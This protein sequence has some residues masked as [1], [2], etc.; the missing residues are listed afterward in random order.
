ML[1]VKS[2]RLLC[3]MFF[4]LHAVFLSVAAVESNASNGNEK[5]CMRS[6]GVEYRGELQSSSSGLT[7]LNWTNTTRDYDVTLHPDSQTGV[8]DHNYCRNPDSS[9]RPWCYI[10]GPDGTVQKQFCALD[11]CKEQVPPVAAE[12]EPLEPSG[13]IPTTKSSE[14]A[15]SEASQGKVAPV[16]P[17]IGISRRVRTGPTKKKDLGTLGYVIG[18]L[19]MAIIILLGVGITVGYF[20]K[21]GR[22]L[23]KHHEQRVYEREMQRIT[24]PLSAFSNP[25]CELVDENTIVIIAE[26]EISPIQEGVE[27][28]DPLMGQH[29]GTPGA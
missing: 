25:T 3:K 24:L 22:D 27:G 29:A 16:Q 20:Y 13:I 8:G 6:N 9:E 18:I 7:C 19:M 1:S 14:P 15:K 12:A 5:D 2:A 4:S 11:T 10:A 17:V 23:K 28:E 26:H 21:R